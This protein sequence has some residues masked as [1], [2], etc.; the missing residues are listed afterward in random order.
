VS[1]HK[2]DWSRVNDHKAYQNNYDEIFRRKTDKPEEIQIHTEEGS[3]PDKQG[4]GDEAR[5]VSSR[6]V[7]QDS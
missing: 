5:S 6:D 2:G 1:S 3:R 7:S 4:E